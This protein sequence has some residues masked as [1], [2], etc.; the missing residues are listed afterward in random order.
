MDKTIRFRVSKNLANRIRHMATLYAGDD[1]SKWLRYA[2][3][4]APRK[5]L[6]KR[7]APRQS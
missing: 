2:A 7:K 6:S 5:F 1:L 3:L 4:A